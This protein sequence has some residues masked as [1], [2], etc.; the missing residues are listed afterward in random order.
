MPGAEYEQKSC[1]LKQGDVLVLFSDGVTESCAP[2]TDQEFGEER[3]IATVRAKRSSTA[4]DMIDAI[5]AELLS[6]TQAAPPADD[7]TLVV[8]RS[9]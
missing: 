8:L 9:T 1:R 6:F 4:S 3:L 2:D 7:I 5:N